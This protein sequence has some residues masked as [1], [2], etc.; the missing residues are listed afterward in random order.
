MNKSLG[1]H[2][3]FGCFL[4]FSCIHWSHSCQAGTS[5]RFR[6]PRVFCYAPKLC[7]IPVNKFL[8]HWAPNTFCLWDQ[9]LLPGTPVSPGNEGGWTLL[10][11]G[12]C[13][14]PGQQKLNKS[15]PSVL[16]AAY[17]FSASPQGTEKYPN[18]L[19][20]YSEQTWAKA[21]MGYANYPG[22]WICW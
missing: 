20:A 6:V 3:T 11:S 10:P 18:C 5:T 16:S 21:G 2:I 15:S 8:K 13:I 19:S 1:R 7:K 9:Q 4:C 12:R 17:L 22:D 14:H